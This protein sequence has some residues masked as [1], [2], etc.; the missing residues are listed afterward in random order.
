MSNYL[1]TSESVSEGHPDKVADQISDAVLDYA[2][3]L[4]STAKCAIET[5][6]AKNLIVVAGET[7]VYLNE[8]IIRNLISK[9]FHSIKT[10]KNWSGF[11]TENYELKL[12]I[13]EQSK[14]INQSVDKVDQTIGAGDQGMMF[15]YACKETDVLMPLP[16][17][18]SH[19]L[20]KYHAY[21][22]KEKGIDW[23]LPDAKSQVTVNYVNGK[24]NKVTHIVLSSQHTEEKSNEEINTFM[25][26]EI[27]KKVIPHDLL[28][29]QTIFHVNP[30]GRFID[31]GPSADTGLTGR[32]IIVDTYGGSAP[33]GGGAFSGKDATKVDRSGAYAA[34]YVA[35]NIV[36]AGFADKCIVQLSYAIGVAEPISINIDLH[37]NG[38]IDNTKLV[39]AV[40][41]I[42]DLTPKG[43]IDS[44]DL[45]K[46]KYSRTSVYGHF[47]KEKFEWEK[48]D[49]AELLRELYN[50]GK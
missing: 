37:G 30:S 3:D 22:R 39:N 40:A 25:I 38:S 1:F 46:P 21:L 16:I 17:Y 2:L 41:K 34:R 6:V 48:T 13:S 11:D 19:E 26:N 15:G 42:F 8:E 4:D 14:D 36:A 5:L 28:T 35:K 44:L 9:V 10:P 12:S 27:I 33:H 23:L 32:K 7:S 18:L 31:G 50:N 47:G 20:L 43:I 49:K 24:P 45:L 29:D